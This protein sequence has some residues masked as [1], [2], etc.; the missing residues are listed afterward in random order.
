MQKLWKFAALFAVNAVLALSITPH[1]AQA[2]V[3]STCYV[4]DCEDDEFGTLHAFWG[5]I[6]EGENAV[7]VGE[8]TDPHTG[9]LPGSCNQ[10]HDTCEPE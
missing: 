2:L 5:E 10:N 9:S 7:N 3:C 1:E 8:Y 4:D 6:C